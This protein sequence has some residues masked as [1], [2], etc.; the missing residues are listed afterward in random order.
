M[1]L[2]YHSVLEIKVCVKVWYK[3]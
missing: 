3:I 1:V 2:K